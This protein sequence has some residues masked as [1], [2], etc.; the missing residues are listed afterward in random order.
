MAATFVTKGY[1]DGIII[2]FQPGSM[3]IFSCLQAM[4]PTS[5]EDDDPVTTDMTADEKLDIMLREH[6]LKLAKSRAESMVQSQQV[7]HAMQVP[8]WQA[9]A[10]IATLP[11]QG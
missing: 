3:A 10:S 1:C 2:Y 6:E 5:T 4:S 9:H 8:H 11:E 7:Q